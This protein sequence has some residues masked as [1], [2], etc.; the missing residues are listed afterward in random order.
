MPWKSGHSEGEL[1]S[2]VLRHW[3]SSPSLP[4]P[5]PSSPPPPPL[6]KSIFLTAISGK[7]ERAGSLAV[8]TISASVTPLQPG[9][10]RVLVATETGNCDLRLRRHRK[11]GLQ[12]HSLLCS[13]PPP[14]PGAQ[15]TPLSRGEKAI[16]RPGHGSFLLTVLIL[17]NFCLALTPS[18][19]SQSRSAFS[20]KDII[21]LAL[22]SLPRTPP[23]HFSFDPWSHPG[24]GWGVCAAERRSQKSGSRLLSEWRLPGPQ[25]WAFL[26]AQPLLW[27]LV[28]VLLEPKRGT[29]RSSSGHTSGQPGALA[30]C[31][32]AFPRAPLTSAETRRRPLPSASPHRPASASLSSHS[33]WYQ[34]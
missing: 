13:R 7:D 10:G 17:R 6:H 15:R 20:Y 21:H 8:W 25:A 27:S 32:Q 31:V 11:L 2:G 1:G 19:S 12:P 4:P 9:K 16:F 18:L 24:W 30:S 3:P 5:H 14:L 33:L 26:P 22:C 23:C 29:I 34:L 28:Q